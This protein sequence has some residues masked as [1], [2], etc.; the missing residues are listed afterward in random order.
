MC[1]F[2]TDETGGRVCK[3]G[4]KLRDLTVLPRKPNEQ[5]P[6]QNPVKNSN[7]FLLLDGSQILH[8]KLPAHPY[9][10]WQRQRSGEARQS[11][12][13]VVIVLW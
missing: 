4:R 5:D 11:V 1:N 2:Q 3:A 8:P 6:P 13:H 7:L 12:A 9:Q 10:A